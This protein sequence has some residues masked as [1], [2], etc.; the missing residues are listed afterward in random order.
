MGIPRS[1]RVCDGRMFHSQRKMHCHSAQCTGHKN[2]ID[3][4]RHRAMIAAGFSPRIVCETGSSATICALVS[5]GLGVAI[6]PR[7]IL[8]TAV[9]ALTIIDLVQPV[10]T[11]TVTVALRSNVYRSAAATA[12]VAFARDAE[13]HDQGVDYKKKDTKQQS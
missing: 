11:P 2:E 7:S 4:L 12:F 9:T 1:L 8:E 6:L 5:A 3:R 10:L 13:N